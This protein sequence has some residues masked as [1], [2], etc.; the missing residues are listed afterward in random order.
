MALRRDSKTGVSVSTAQYN[1]QP[2]IMSFSRALGAL[3]L[4][5]LQVLA[6][7]HACPEQLL[8]VNDR[9]LRKLINPLSGL[10]EVIGSSNFD[11]LA[12]KAKLESLGIATSH[13]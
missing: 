13:C 10:D 8:K 4:V 7:G 1:Q 5:V 9:A 3:H 2:L 11:M 6:M 12:F